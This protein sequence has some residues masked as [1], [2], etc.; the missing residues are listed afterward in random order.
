MKI[1]V[2]TQFFSFPLISTFPS[3]TPKYQNL[4]VGEAEGED[5]GMNSYNVTISKS[6]GHGQSQ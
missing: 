5:G 3:T 2:K 4:G 1:D 6:R